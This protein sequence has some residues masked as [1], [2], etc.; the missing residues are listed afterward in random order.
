MT[1]TALVVFTRDLRVHDNPTLRGAVDAADRVV[2]LF[3]ID[4][5]IADSGFGCPNRAAFLADCLHDLDAGLRR[6]GSF[7]VMRRGDP[8]DQIAQLADR[9]N[10]SSIHVSLDWSAYAQRRSE[11]LRARLTA[12]GRALVEYAETIPLVPPGSVHPQGKDHYSVFTPFHRRWSQ[13]VVRTPLDAPERI[14]SRRVDRG[15]VPTVM[16]LGGGNPA[17]ELPA[18]GETAGRA[19]LD[20][21]M[22]DAVHQYADHGDDLS[23]DATSHLSAYLHFGC[24]SPVEVAARAGDSAG[25]AAL[26]RQLAW[27]DFH[28]Q[29]LAARPDASRRDYRGRGDRWRRGGEDFVAWSEGR[30][31]IPIVDAGMRQLVREGWM[32]N[33]TRMI[34]AS[35]LTKHLYVDWREGAAYFLNHLVDGDIAQN[36]LN[37]QWVAGTGTDTRP[38]RVLNPI[39]QAERFDPHGTYVRRYVDELASIGGRRVHRPWDLSP[40]ERAELDYPYPVVNLDDARRAFHTARGETPDAP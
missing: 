5:R 15:S 8:I 20:A 34:V 19:R 23:A 37:W 33:R 12:D 26:L 1:T 35:F 4:E 14:S 25:G 39:R 6:L 22:R 3:V 9:L 17:P 21:W 29:V 31:G 30:T 24:V 2:A 10:A 13:A 36:Q 28:L 18:G 32:H 40:E 27:R 7:L 16:E 38:N 11:R